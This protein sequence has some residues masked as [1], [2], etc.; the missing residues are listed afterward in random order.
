MCMIQNN[1]DKH[2][3]SEGAH[4]KKEW[5]KLRLYRICDNL[6]FTIC[7]Y[8]MYVLK[9]LTLLMTKLRTQGIDVLFTS[10][11]IYIYYL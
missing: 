11:Y 10:I 7:L 1:Y 8:E 3:S 6:N 4:G 9:N 5:E 2:S